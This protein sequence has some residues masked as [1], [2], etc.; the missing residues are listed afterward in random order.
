MRAHVL[1]APAQAVTQKVARVAV[2]VEPAVE[3]ASAAP[4]VQAALLRAAQVAR[5]P[6]STRLYARHPL[7]CWTSTRPMHAST[8]AY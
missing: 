2:E 7:S 6:Q 8:S 5:L 4:E 3:V 1:T